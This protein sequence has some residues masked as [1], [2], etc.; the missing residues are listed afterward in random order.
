LRWHASIA[1]GSVI[2][3][4]IFAARVSKPETLVTVVPAAWQVENPLRGAAGEIRNPLKTIMMDVRLIC[5][6]LLFHLQ[7][8]S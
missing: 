8:A 5:L 6:I 4:V 2:S 3:G 7:T 1:S